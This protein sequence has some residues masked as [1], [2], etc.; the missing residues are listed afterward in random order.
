MRE[1]SIHSVRRDF[2]LTRE[3]CPVNVCAGTAHA[4]DGLSV[5]LPRHV[6]K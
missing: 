1:Q 6:P 4:N 3:S 5:V 2:E